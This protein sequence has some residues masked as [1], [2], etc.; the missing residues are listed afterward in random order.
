MRTLRPR[1]LAQV[2]LFSAAGV[3]ADLIDTFSRL[4]ACSFMVMV[5]DFS[6]IRICGALV[7]F[8]SVTVP[9]IQYTV[10]DSEKS[11]GA[12]AGVG[13]VFGAAEPV[14][15]AEGFASGSVLRS[16]RR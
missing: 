2:V 14:E 9:A 8:T 7:Q 3:P 16:I 15:V 12:G 10:D 13:S 1:R 5:C 4:A 11:G 6:V